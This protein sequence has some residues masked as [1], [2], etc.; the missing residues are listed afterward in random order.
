MFESTHKN[1]WHDFE[2]LPYLGLVPDADVARDDLNTAFDKALSVGLGSIPR[3]TS[4]AIGLTEAWRLLTT[5]PPCM[6]VAPTTT[7]KGAEGSWE[8]VIVLR[9][10]LLSRDLIQCWDCRRLVKRGAFISSYPGPLSKTWLHHTDCRDGEKSEK[11]CTFV[12]KCAE[13]DRWNSD[14]ATRLP[15]LRVE[16]LGVILEQGNYYD[17][18]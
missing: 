7:I 12:C 11:A 4:H 16:T 18:G 2:S 15:R 14:T 6:P 1:I 9:P 10:F 8:I 13:R 17:K 5:L 3:Q